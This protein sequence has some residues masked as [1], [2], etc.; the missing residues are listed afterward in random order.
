MI[1][2]F[3]STHCCCQTIRVLFRVLWMYNFEKNEERTRS[4]IGCYKETSRNCSHG[5]Q[6][7]SC[8]ECVLFHVKASLHSSIVHK[9]RFFKVLCTPKKDIVLPFFRQKPN[10]PCMYYVLTS[11]WRTFLNMQI[12][13]WCLWCKK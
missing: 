3:T 10:F 11:R 2:Y 6:R 4:C 9:V 13:P 7:L 12:R 5:K 8:L 1:W